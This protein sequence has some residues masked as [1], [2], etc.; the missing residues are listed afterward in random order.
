MEDTVVK[1]VMMVCVA[2]MMVSVASAQ[3]S[4]KVTTV[5][6]GSG[7][8]PITGGV[9][10]SVDLS[11]ETGGY[12]QIMAQSQ[13]AW[14]MMGKDWKFGS[15]HKC[16]LYG[17][18][19]H[20]QSAPWVGPYAGCNL[21]V[22]KVFGQDVVIGALTWPGWYIGREPMDWQNDGVK[23]TEATYVGYFSMATASIGALQLSLSH[24]NFLDEPTNWLPG[25]GYNQK[26]RSDTEV[27]GNVTW[28]PNADRA[29]YYIGVV[30]HP[31][32]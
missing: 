13:Q 32:K 31:K 2:L 23:N 11:T 10:A 18:V 16:S 27:T 4:F 19:G 5:S 3:D 12:I 24:L 15:G 17:S 29:M 9:S 22:A 28:N 30:W 20:F 26:V 21:N 7:E 8:T 14:F 1:S 6:I 25:V